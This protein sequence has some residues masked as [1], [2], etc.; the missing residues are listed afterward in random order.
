MMSNTEIDPTSSPFFTRGI[1]RK[2]FSFIRRTA[3]PIVASGESVSTF[4]CIHSEIGES[5][6]TFSPRTLVSRSRSVQI[7]ATQ[8]SSCGLHC[9]DSLVQR[10]VRRDG[11]VIVRLQDADPLVAGVSQT[12][13]WRN[14][15]PQ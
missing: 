11:D 9:Y 1:F 8:P 12:G 10:S 5:R 3:S 13:A 15:L 6:L 2:L 4:A 14:R 7:P